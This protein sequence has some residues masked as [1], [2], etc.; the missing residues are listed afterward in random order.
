M[1]DL[2]VVA[3]ELAE[4]SY[5]HR[6]KIQRLESQLEAIACC[7]Y[8]GSKDSFRDMMKELE[9]TYMWDDSLK[10]IEELDKDRG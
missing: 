9:K 6:E 2:V 10:K 1:S 8:T 4:Q 3:E 5:K 7:F